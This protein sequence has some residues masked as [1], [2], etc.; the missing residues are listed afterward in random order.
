M[1]CSYL[2]YILPDDSFD[3]QVHSP[4]P[5]DNSQHTDVSSDEGSTETNDT[6]NT[7]TDITDSTD[8]TDPTGTDTTDRAT[9]GECSFCACWLVIFCSWARRIM[10][11]LAEHTKS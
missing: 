10:P 9:T 1:T 5:A 11:I 6:T 8:T 3:E 4:I 7:S 2:L